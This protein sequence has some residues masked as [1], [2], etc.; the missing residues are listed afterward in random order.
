[1]ETWLKRHQYLAA[2]AKQLHFKGAV[3]AAQEQASA[4]EEE[5]EM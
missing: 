3:L 1:M 2:M 5:G 4:E